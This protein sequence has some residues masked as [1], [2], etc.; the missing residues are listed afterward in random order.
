MASWVLLHHW[1]CI[2][3]GD[4]GDG[5]GEVETTSFDPFV[6]NDVL[7]HVPWLDLYDWMS[8]TRTKTC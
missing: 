3:G 8:P 6:L 4:D 5:L 7:G 1:D 2:D